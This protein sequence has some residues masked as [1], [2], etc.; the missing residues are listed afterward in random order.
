MP[1]KKREESEEESDKRQTLFFFSLSLNISCL[2]KFLFAF[3]PFSDLVKAETV[4]QSRRHLCVL[5][6]MF[7]AAVG[8]KKLN[9]FIAGVQSWREVISFPQGISSLF[10]LKQDLLTPGGTFTEDVVEW[11]YGKYRMRLQE[12]PTGFPREELLTSPPQTPPPSDFSCL[13]VF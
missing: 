1:E 2:K 10:R 8:M 3:L 9:Y 7:L 12:T 11:H 5:T 13:F 4:N 6:E